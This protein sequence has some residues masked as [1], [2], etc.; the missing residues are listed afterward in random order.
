[1][2][3]TTAS[4]ETTSG[5]RL[6]EIARSIFTSVGIL[7]ILL[8]VAILY[9]ASQE[10]RFYGPQNITNVLRQSTFLIIV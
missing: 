2:S 6:A 8:V 7:P 1:M 4:R 10:A 3:A 9:F 5:N